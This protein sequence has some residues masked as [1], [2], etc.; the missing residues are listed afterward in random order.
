M[1]RMVF[2]SHQRDEVKRGGQGAQRTAHGRYEVESPCDLAGLMSGSHQQTHGI[3]RDHAHDYRWQY[4]Q[5]AGRQKR[6][7]AGILDPFE[8]EYHGR[9]GGI[10]ERVEEDGGDGEDD[11]EAFEGRPMQGEFAA[12]QVAESQ[13]EHE[14]GDDA[15][16]DVDAGS[17]V[18]REYP[19][20]Q[21]FQ[22]H[23]DKTAGEGES[24]NYR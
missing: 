5:Q 11:A 14:H 21:E 19:S 20:T 1:V 6:P 15:A 3:G 24:I 17:E 8:D 13:G 2:I 16:P 23:D 22:R 4:E 7:V 10:D 9:F 12:E 18:G